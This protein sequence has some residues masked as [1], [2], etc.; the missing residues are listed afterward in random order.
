MISDKDVQKNM[1][2]NV[3]C[4]EMKKEK[5]CYGGP[6]FLSFTWDQY[7]EFSAFVFVKHR[8]KRII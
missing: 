3:K 5:G 8:F 7:I 1:N 2:K 4:C 6:F